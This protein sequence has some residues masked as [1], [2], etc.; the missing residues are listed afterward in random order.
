MFPASYYIIVNLI[1]V[2]SLVNE[3]LITF[4]KRKKSS[5]RTAATASEGIA[6]V[7]VIAQKSAV[8]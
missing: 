8:V 1:L 4:I 7:A 5:C 2:F 6:E 3:L